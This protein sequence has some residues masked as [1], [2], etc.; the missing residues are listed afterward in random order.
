MADREIHEAL[1]KY[2]LI[3]QQQVEKQRAEIKASKKPLPRAK[4]RSDSAAMWATN[5]D[6]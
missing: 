6:Q 1:Q 4:S 5:K 2:Q 3:I